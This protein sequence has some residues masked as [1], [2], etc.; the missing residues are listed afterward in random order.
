MSVA[1]VG[2]VEH[3]P[4]AHSGGV[5]EGEEVCSP[6]NAGDVAI[7]KGEVH[8]A[9]VLTLEL[10][11]TIVGFFRAVERGQTQGLRITPRL[12]CCQELDFVKGTTVGLARQRA[13]PL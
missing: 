7:G 13:H 5:D 11:V 3:P 4:V 12:D 10:P 1:E 2:R 6:A 9:D 8:P